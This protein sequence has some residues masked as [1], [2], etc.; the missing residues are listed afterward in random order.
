MKAI[1]YVVLT[2]FL[3]S[4]AHAADDV[5]SAVHGTVEKVDSSTKTILVKTADGTKHS[6][7]A[8]EQTSVHGT[9][10]LGKNSW[11]GIENGSEVV[12]HYTKRGG[13]DTAV[14][15]DKVGK[16]GLKATTG[17]VKS[18]DRAGKTIV[19]K[20]GEGTEETFRLT[21]HAAVDAGKGVAEG[22]EKGSKVVVYSSDEAGK[23][24]AHFFEK[25]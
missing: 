13:Q 10:D 23:K 20:T 19:V 4:A 18:I 5:V 15:I 12:V 3:A 6:F 16:D 1:T 25:I 17:T 14:E 2:I 7:R 22:A 21:D 11:H 24:V 8:V 9:A